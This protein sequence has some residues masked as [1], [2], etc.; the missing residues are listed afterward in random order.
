LWCAGLSVQLVVGAKTVV[1]QQLK[2]QLAT[3]TAKRF[4]TQPLFIIFT[5]FAA[6]VAAGFYSGH[7][8]R[9]YD[10]SKR[11]LQRRQ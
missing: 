8:R 5:G 2:Y 1:V 6:V 9:L 7:T 10:K 4:I 3:L 11:G